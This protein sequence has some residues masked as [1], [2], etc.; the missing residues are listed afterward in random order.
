MQSASLLF[1]SI[2]GQNPPAAAEADR[3]MPAGSGY[4]FAAVTTISTRI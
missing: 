3:P 4:F 2:S 1:G